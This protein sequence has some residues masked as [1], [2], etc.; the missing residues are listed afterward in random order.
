MRSFPLSPRQMF[1]HTR[2]SLP[3][4]YF[5]RPDPPK[6][7]R[8]HAAQRRIVFPSTIPRNPPRRRASIAKP[9]RPRGSPPRPR[10]SPPKL[11][12]PFLSQ[13]KSPHL[14]QSLPKTPRPRLPESLRPRLSLLYSRSTCNMFAPLSTGATWPPCSF[15]LRCAF[16][17]SPAH[18]LQSLGLG[19]SCLVL[20]PQCRRHVTSNCFRHGATCARLLY[21]RSTHA[22][23]APRATRTV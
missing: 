11:Q 14:R 16:I 18:T 10:P 22:M 21:I 23:I 5:L 3:N 7:E 8:P 15:E 4:I 17:D 12:R 6:M 20:L 19:H 1:P 2:L 9:P 13:P